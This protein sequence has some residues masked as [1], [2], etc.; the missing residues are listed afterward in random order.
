[1]FTRAGTRKGGE[2][3]Y[4]I[5]KHL[6]LESQ[7]RQSEVSVKQALSSSLTRINSYFCALAPTN[8]SLTLPGRVS[9][10]LLIKIKLFDYIRGWTTIYKKIPPCWVNFYVNQALKLKDNS[11]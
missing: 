10:T 8:P 2:I 1:M 3:A 11:Y 4:A 5:E 6:E 9:H 7:S